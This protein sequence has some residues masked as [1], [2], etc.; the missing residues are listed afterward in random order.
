M[1]IYIYRLDEKQTPITTLCP[2]T[3]RLPEQIEALRTWVTRRRK[4]EPLGCIADVGFC[5]RKDAG[6]GGSS[7][8]PEIMKRLADYGVTVFLSEYPGYA[9][10]EKK[11]K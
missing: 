4:K 9:E 8:T 3:W 10:S 7:L 6:G 5:W 11:T 2:D 1:P